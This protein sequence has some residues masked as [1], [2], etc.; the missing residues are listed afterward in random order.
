MAW[1]SFKHVIKA[2]LLS[3]DGRTQS[4]PS[5]VLGYTVTC[6]PGRHLEL[7]QNQTKQQHPIKD[8]DSAHSRGRDRRISVSSRP[9]WSIF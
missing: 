5:P 2:E 9:V 6:V 4:H 1:G 3:G 8:L 7:G